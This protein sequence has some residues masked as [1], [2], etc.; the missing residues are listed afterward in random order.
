MER[1]FF[2]PRVSIVQSEIS[3]VYISWNLIS[4]FRTYSSFY[5]SFYLF[6]ISLLTK[7]QANISNFKFL[8]GSQVLFPFFFLFFFHFHTKINFQPLHFSRDIF[9]EPASNFAQKILN[10]HIC[11]RKGENFPVP[12]FCNEQQVAVTQKRIEMQN[13]TCN[14]ATILR[15]KINSSYVDQNCYQHE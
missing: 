10:V 4:Y 14:R 11:T 8:F 6:P 7:Y 3:L 1:D 15:S 9:A 13:T 5:R 2:R 12:F